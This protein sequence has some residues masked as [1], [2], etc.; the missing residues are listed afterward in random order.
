[1]SPP[2]L[3]MLS[4]ISIETFR[5]DLE[6]LEAMAISSYRDEYGIESF[7]NLYK[8]SYLRFLFDRIPDKSHLIAAYRGDEIVS[9]F[10]NLPRKYHY[11][12]NVYR[13]VLSCILVTRKEYLR[14]GVALA[15]IAEALKVNSRFNYDFAT[16]Y[17]ETG[18]R[19]TKMIKKLK[20]AGNPVEWV[21]KMYVVGRVL[22]LERVSVCEGIRKWESAL[23]R[24]V[25]AAK[26]PRPKK[27]EAVR[28]YGPGDID[29]C[30]S[31]L[32]GYKDKAG[33]A[34]VW[35]RG[36]L[37]WELD[38]PDVSKTLV[39]E[40][41]GRVQG[42]INWVYHDH[43]GKTKER[44]AWINHVAWPGLSGRERLDF[45]NSFLLYLKGL[46]CVGAIEWTKKYYPMDALYRS[47]FF[48]YFR[49]VNML[50]WNFNPDVRIKNIPDV[51]EVQI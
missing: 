14:K 17:F 9:F 35:D 29:D 19:S 4:D 11:Q 31:L 40:K 28:E 36:E 50:S 10:A 3:I 34:L 12:G 47:R 18:H 25:G 8:P 44:W 15:I 7:P 6:G 33:L 30:L 45:I 41:D 39:Y 22:D 16:M 38:Y 32:N 1:M 2:D 5:G 37:A 24:V 21:K 46:D 23:I 27:S 20:E 48:P 26:Q 51:Y 42:L 49:A 43:L 13:G